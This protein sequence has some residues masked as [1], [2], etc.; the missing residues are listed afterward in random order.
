[1]H[2]RRRSSGHGAVRGWG[3]IAAHRVIVH[4]GVAG[5]GSHPVSLTNILPTGRSEKSHSFTNSTPVLIYFLFELRPVVSHLCSAPSHA[6]CILHWAPHSVPP[7]RCTLICGVHTAPGH[8]CGTPGFLRQHLAALS[9]IK[10]IAVFMQFSIR[11]RRANCV[12]WQAERCLPRT[13][14]CRRT[15]IAELLPSIT[16]LVRTS[17]SI[18]PSFRGATTTAHRETRVGLFNIDLGCIG[19]AYTVQV[20]WGY[21]VLMYGRIYRS[22]LQLSTSNESYSRGSMHIPPGM[23]I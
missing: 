12:C 17:G 23:K 21:N 4:W 9:G 20:Y 7:L 1:M 16:L 15:N 5:T 10:A 11:R 3:G 13:C 2:V 18:S 8:K 14:P 6:G 19:A 22:R